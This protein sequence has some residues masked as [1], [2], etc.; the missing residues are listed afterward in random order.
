MIHGDAGRW[1]TM[2]HKVDMGSI[3]ELELTIDS[4]II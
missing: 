3:E 4:T 2:V 1:V